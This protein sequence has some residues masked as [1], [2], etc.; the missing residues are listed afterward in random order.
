LDPCPPLLCV[1]ASRRQCACCMPHVMVHAACSSRGLSRRLELCGLFSSGTLEL[2]SAFVAKNGSLFSKLNVNEE[3]CLRKMRLLAICTVGDGMQ[4]GWSRQPQPPRA[5]H[6]HLALV[7]SACRMRLCRLGD[8]NLRAAHDGVCASAL[9]SPKCFAR[10][11]S[12]GR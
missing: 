2:Y 1:D 4:V 5:C 11:G 12:Y 6:A 10:G 9:R 3:E 7:N 8:L